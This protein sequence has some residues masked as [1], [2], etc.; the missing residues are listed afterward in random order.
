MKYHIC[1][2]RDAKGIHVGTGGEDAGTRAVSSGGI[3]FENG[4]K[5]NRSISVDVLL[6]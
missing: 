1:H 5:I 2:N 3:L 6:T 4:K